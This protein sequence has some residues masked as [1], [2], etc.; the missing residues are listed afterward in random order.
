[1]LS[2]IEAV[3]S[4]WKKT[5]TGRASAVEGNYIYE[6]KR[7]SLGTEREAGTDCT[8]EEGSDD[9]AAFLVVVV[10]LSTSKSFHS[11]CQ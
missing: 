7:V 3:V 11:E 10:L 8:E 2:P 1:M 4:E 5:G 9:F 6:M